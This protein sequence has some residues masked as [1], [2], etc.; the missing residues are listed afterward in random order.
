MEYLV[1]KFWGN[2]AFI[3][4]NVKISNVRELVLK[5]WTGLNRLSTG[6]SGRLQ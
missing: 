2:R 3:M 5:M 4:I 1:E 6:Y